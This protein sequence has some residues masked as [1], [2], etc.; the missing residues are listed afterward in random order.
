[1][2]RVQFPWS[3]GVSLS[4]KILSHPVYG[5]LGPNKKLRSF[6]FEKKKFI[7]VQCSSDNRKDDR[8][9]LY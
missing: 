8:F 6:I 4:T 3:R 5:T 9:K 2:V 1:M 7:L